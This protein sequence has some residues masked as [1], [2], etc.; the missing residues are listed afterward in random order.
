MDGGFLPEPLPAL[1]ARRSPPPDR[2]PVCPPPAH[3]GACP[4]WGPY[5][6][7]PPEEGCSRC[8]ALTFNQEWLQHFGVA[9]CNTCKHDERL[10]TTTAAK[11]QFRLTDGDL[12][13]LGSI[14]RENKKN[15]AWQPMRLYMQSQVERA[16]NAKYG[17]PG[18]VEARR[19]EVLDAQMEARK[20]RK[21]EEQR[22]SEREAEVRRRVQQRMREEH[23]EPGA[24]AAAE[25]D[26]EEI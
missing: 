23:A 26:V 13:K 16:A 9:L 20:R 19:L 12:R 6:E 17:G 14:R 25:A 11:Q 7:Q 2:P 24:P 1:P 8:G 4:T 21:D 15:S 10:M 18:G 5:E 3:T 22:R